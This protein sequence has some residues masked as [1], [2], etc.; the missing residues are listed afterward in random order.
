[1][2]KIEYN[3]TTPQQSIWAMEQFYKNTSINNICG[4]FVVK[5]TLNFN[6]LEKAIN[7]F[8]DT[9]PS[10]NLRLFFEE[11]GSIKQYFINHEFQKIDLIS[12]NNNEELSKLEKDLVNKPFSLLN[13]DLFK[14]VMYKFPDGTG[15]VIAVA[16]HLIAD[17]FTASILTNKL[18][19]I[20]NGLLNKQ[21]LTYDN[22]SYE[23]YILSEK[24]YKESVRFEK[25]KAYWK[26]IFSTF[27][28]IASLSIKTNKK[29][30]TI[31]NCVS[32]RESF[33]IDSS[34]LSRINSYCKNHRISKYNFFMAVYSLYIGK[35]NDLN[36][37]TIG[38]PILNRKNFKEKNTTGMFINTLPFRCTFKENETFIEYLSEVASNS[39]NMLRHQRYSYEYILKDIREEN[40]NIPTLYNILLSYQIG[41]SDH[42]ETD[43]D[44]TVHWTHSD[45]NADELD[46]H[47]FDYDNDERVLTIAYDYQLKKHSKQDILDLHKR[48]TNIIEQVL[49]DSSLK[50]SQYELVT[51]E[52]KDFILNKYN[53]SDNIEIT[54]TVIDLFEEQVF[55]NPDKIAI[56]KN[57][58]NFTYAEFN[59]MV[60]S[61]VE[62]LKENGLMPHDNVC[63]FFNNSIELVVAI[64][65]VLKSSACYI[66]IDVS[67]PNDRISYIIQDSGSKLILT[68][69][70]NVNKLN[71]LTK[72]S[73]LLDLDFIKSKATKEYPN[74]TIKPTL[75][76]LAYTIYTSGS[77]GKPKG[78]KI[79]HE[80]L[81]NYILW[82]Q[83]TYV[84]D[85]VT[86]FPLYSSISFDLTVTSVFT[87]LISGYAIYVYEN[88]KP[89]LLLKDIIDDKKVQLIKLTPAHLT[90]LLD[91]VT[92]TIVTKLIVGGD[93]LTTETCKKITTLFNNNVSIFNEYGPTE[94]TVGCMTY[95]YTFED[96]NM[97]TS[98]PIGIPGDN[99]TIL[100]LNND[101]NLIPF[102]YSGQ[103]YI[104]GKCLSKGYVNLDKINK[105]RFIPSP[106][107]ENETLYT[108][109]DI[110]KLYSNGIMEYVG[111]KDFQVKINGYRIETGEIQSKILNF[112]SVK[113][114]FVH[115]LESNQTH[116]LCAYY[117]S[118]KDFDLN[119]L[120]NYLISSL[121]KYMVPKYFVK[122]DKIPLT[123]NGKVDKASLPAP[124]NKTNQNYLAPESELEKLLHDIFALLLNVEKISVTDNLFDY[125]IDSL[126]IIKAQTKLYS[127]GYSIDTQVFYTYNSIREIANNINSK[128]M[129][130][131]NTCQ[132]YENLN[133][134]EIK[135]PINL[136]NN[137]N[138]ILL[139]GST[140]FL[141][142]HLLH[143]LLEHTN[144]N[145]YCIIREKD[146]IDSIE[147][148]K[149]KYNFYF[150]DI[151][152]YLNRMTII[153][154][155]LLQE[156]FNLNEQIY[157]SICSKIDCV[158]SS[159]A[160]VK[161]F[162]DE[163]IFYNTNVLGTQK[164]ID[165][166]VENNVPLHY[167]S[168]LS[169][170]GFGL[171]QTPSCN[172]TE[173][174][175]YIKQNYKDNIYVKTKFEAE[176][177]ILTACKN[178]NLNA[179]IYRVGNLSNRFSDGV[180]QEN[181]YENA[182]LNRISSIINLKCI[183]EEILNYPMEL[184]PVDLCAK[185]IIALS[186]ISKDNLNI[187]HLF[188]QNYIKF[189]D[190]VDIAK[191]NNF[192]IKKVSLK[193][194]EE[195]LRNSNLNTFGIKN[196]ISSIE[197][198]SSLIIL[199]NN[200]TNEILKSNNTIWPAINTDYI[201]K[202]IEYL[203]NN[204]FIGET[205]EN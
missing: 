200:Y 49:E 86:N 201:N 43:I 160:I 174:D 33:E 75:T 113:D 108:A 204:K 29:Y 88:D 134:S 159:A 13:S 153:T 182:F 103:M 151:N 1:M 188:N 149:Q 83:K 37:F 198:P 87:P 120:R 199:N 168:T 140:G 136:T 19:Y 106:F 152:T 119:D 155:D 5:D 74:L 80:S 72:Y 52:E 42:S 185:Y 191:I 76:D 172:F 48:I 122:V 64:F 50:L 157:N 131:D 137:Y 130:N 67:Y 57:G 173:N 39:L 3:L 81:A 107:K 154:G 194:F 27:P 23:D 16:H 179:S 21:E 181:A 135:H 146:N 25:D 82:S 2:E 143:E 124:T 95:V 100:L 55:K 73:L 36:D 197:N 70:E 178:N 175:F 202:I 147:R 54:N 38:T 94:A 96:E 79:A 9:N 34:T 71:E 66:P 117:V 112:D 180:F 22:C 144:A 115:V 109:G 4:T 110:S 91:V 15:G 205:N 163:K 40:Y 11:D 128:K 138:N 111:R 7:T 92:D 20:Y 28:E 45:S 167:V 162:G 97:Y 60:N 121:P 105:E 123:V 65:A 142:I 31:Q 46:I 51:P 90:L 69:S 125:M 62:Y 145:I 150:N 193:D 102:G 77:T 44:Y 78:V 133:I 166:C 56:S 58:T 169:V 84:K 177:R 8:I 114:C 104:G 18:L 127:L 192:E 196:Y 6:I 53:S 99:A 158:F 24:E 68:N 126:T 89:Q 26:N 116:V 139:F 129:I 184:T 141:G 85:E 101:L 171:V 12:L 156:N 195:V 59:N 98:V 14:F 170:S 63:L 30:D 165:F 203:K 183:P 189:K 10:F 93:I 176:G 186:T 118:E 161:H 41:R 35:V 190:F 47:I 17:A 164:I 148:F 32:S 132:E 61:T 187:Y